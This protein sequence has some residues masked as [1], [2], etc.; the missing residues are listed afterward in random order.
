[1]NIK[2]KYEKEKFL[3]TG[4]LSLKNYITSQVT[5]VLNNWSY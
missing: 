1:M 4:E 2:A 3:V 5:F